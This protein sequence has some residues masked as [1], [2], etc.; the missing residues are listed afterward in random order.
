MR[1]RLEIVGDPA[2]QCLAEASANGFREDY[3]RVVAFYAVKSRPA[4]ALPKLGVL[5]EVRACGCERLGVVGG[6]N[7][8]ACA[9]AEL[10]AEQS[11]A[12]HGNGSRGRAEDFQGDSGS[13]PRR[14]DDNTR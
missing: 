14:R 5:V 4:D 1:V 10:S 2:C 13:E 12:H 9:P 6:E 3:G 7:L 11:R 8:D